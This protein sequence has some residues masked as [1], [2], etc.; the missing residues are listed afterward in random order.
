MKQCSAPRTH[1]H[2]RWT[3]NQIRVHSYFRYNRISEQSKMLKPIHYYRTIIRSKDLFK[4]QITDI[5]TVRLLRRY[6]YCTLDKWTSVFSQIQYFL[7]LAHTPY[8]CLCVYASI[9]GPHLHLIILFNKPI[10]AI[11]DKGR[12]NRSRHSTKISHNEQNAMKSTAN[13]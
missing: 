2:T 1:I 7:F 12:N 9:I 6:G 3:Y 11:D 13:P 10:Y 4:Q 5:V 8:V